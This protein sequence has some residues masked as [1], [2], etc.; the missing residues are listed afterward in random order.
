MTYQPSAEVV[1]TTLLSLP[2]EL[3]L[4]VAE[5]LRFERYVNTFSQ[6]SRRLY[7]LL[8]TYLYQ[9]D[10]KYGYALTW[11]AKY[12]NQRTAQLSIAAGVDVNQEVLVFQ[13]RYW[14]YT[15]LQVAVWSEQASVARL[16]IE[17]NARSTQV[18]SRKYNMSTVLHVASAMGLA[19]VVKNLLD[20]GAN[21]HARD[22]QGRT[23]LHSAVETYK[24]RQVH[25][26]WDEKEITILWLLEYGADP[27]AFDNRGR[28]P[29]ILAEK[30]PNPF[31]RMMLRKGSNH[32]LYVAMLQEEDILELQRQREKN[33][34]IR[35][36]RRAAER[37]RRLQPKSRQRQTKTRKD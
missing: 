35:R 2:N 4:S 29:R 6:T 37:S 14:C 23:P 10:A 36:K 27:D 28:Q 22:G 11:A 8:N 9:R 25:W 33:A 5:H 19:L 24:N 15:P 13:G 1:R 30:H 18:Y 32:A 31:V 20:K 17:N 3:L 16:L 21:I 12:G 34:T 26:N 7:S